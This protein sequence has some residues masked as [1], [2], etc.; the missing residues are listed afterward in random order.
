LLSKN[1][2]IKTYTTIILPV[3]LY[4]C[5]TSPLTLRE[6]HRLGE[7]ENRALKKI[8]G[9]KREEVKGRWRR[10][11][12]EE[13]CDQQLLLGGQITKNKDVRGMWLVWGDRGSVYSVLVGR[14]DVK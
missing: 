6:K 14:I 10:L 8:S 9:L 4:G 13:L 2:K 7:F 5:E 3:V 1:I 12:S 11:R